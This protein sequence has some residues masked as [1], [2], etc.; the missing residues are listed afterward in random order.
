MFYMHKVLRIEVNFYDR[1][2]DFPQYYFGCFFFRTLTEIVVRSLN[3]NS[4]KCKNEFP[5]GRKRTRSV[6]EKQ[7]PQYYTGY[8]LNRYVR[9][10][11]KL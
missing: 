4:K 8:E 1:E 10:P 7:F 2:S 9:G 5:V 11:I 3:A 6:V